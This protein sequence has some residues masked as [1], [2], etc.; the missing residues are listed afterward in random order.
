MGQLDR[1][2][3]ELMIRDQELDHIKGD[4][5]AQAMESMKQERVRGQYEQLIHTLE[6][7]NESLKF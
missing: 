7:E 3:E 5:Q 1:M 2:Q 4:F 6:Q